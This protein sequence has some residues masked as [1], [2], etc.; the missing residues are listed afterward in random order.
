MS[1]VYFNVHGYKSGGQ[2]YMERFEANSFVSRNKRLWFGNKSLNNR[3][4]HTKRGHYNTQ[5][6]V[7]VTVQSAVESRIFETL[8]RL[9]TTAQLGEQQYRCCYGCV[10]VQAP[11]LRHPFGVGSPAMMVITLASVL[12]VPNAT[13]TMNTTIDR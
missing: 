12:K 8:L 9:S 11:A 5:M 3:C 6:A 7:A 2:L 13:P 4:E 1:A 10:M